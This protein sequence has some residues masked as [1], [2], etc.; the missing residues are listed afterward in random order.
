MLFRSTPYA[1]HPSRPVPVA[2]TFSNKKGNVK[3]NFSL[4]SNKLLLKKPYLRPVSRETKHKMGPKDD[5]GI[6]RTYIEA[7]LI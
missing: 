4:C 7:S 3:I 1:S 2:L 6:G 5:R